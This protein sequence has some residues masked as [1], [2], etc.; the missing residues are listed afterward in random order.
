MEFADAPPLCFIEGIDMGKLVD[1]PA[2][3]ARHNLTFNLLQAAA[4]S[5][6]AS[7]ALVESVA[8]AYE[9]GEQHH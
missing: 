1:D 2:T 5:P 4:L 6:Q 9:H 7:L 8:H 3:V